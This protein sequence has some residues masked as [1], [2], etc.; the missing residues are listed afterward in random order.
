M[1]NYPR[2]KILYNLNIGLIWKASENITMGFHCINIIP[3]NNYY[4]TVPQFN[5]SLVSG[6]RY[7]LNDNFSL[8]A[9]A[10]LNPYVGYSI[11]FGLEYNIIKNL[12]LETGINTHFSN[13]YFAFGFTYHFKKLKVGCSFYKNTYLP[14]STSIEFSYIF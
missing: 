3:Y 10:E 5:I 7:Y 13:P 4:Q 1:Y 6:I 2:Q 8:L 14:F 12:C 11:N 9:Q